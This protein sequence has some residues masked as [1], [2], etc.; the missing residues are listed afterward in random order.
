MPIPVAAQSKA[1]V[2][3]RPIAGILGSNPAG[4]LCCML[5]R[6]RDKPEQS[7]HEKS[8]KEEQATNFRKIS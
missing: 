4:V 5:Y 3:G 6:Q 8:T 2:C 7:R 1:Y